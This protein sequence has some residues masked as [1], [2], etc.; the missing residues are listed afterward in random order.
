MNC[1]RP[2]R[3]SGEDG[4]SQ[5]VRL[6]VGREQRYFS[7]TCAAQLHTQSLGINMCESPRT[8]Q[9]EHFYK[10]IFLKMDNSGPDLYCLHAYINIIILHSLYVEGKVQHFGKLHLF[11]FFLE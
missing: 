7:S 1:V 10:Y 3:G 6:S 8:V 5:S 11:A 9:T 2:T 4:I